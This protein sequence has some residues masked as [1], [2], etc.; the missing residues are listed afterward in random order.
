MT[1]NMRGQKSL[2][3]AAILLVS[4][5][6]VL[7]LPVH[8]DQSSAQAELNSAR[9]RLADCFS[10]I[11][12]AEA[13]S[14]NIS[15]L[16]RTLNSAGILFSQAELVYSAG[17]FGAA[18]VFAVQSQNLLSNFISNAN[19]LETEATLRHDQDFLFNFVGSILGLV[20]V[21]VGSFVVWVLLKRK[22]GKDEGVEI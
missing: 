20:A 14:A 18:Q 6:C 17:D 12:A 16:T 8:A 19:S 4:V 13:A 3:F 15:E 9:L 22:Y 1:T 5:V 7:P 21:L 2:F 11:R 10:A